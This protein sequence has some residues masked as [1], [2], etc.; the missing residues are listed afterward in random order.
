LLI[1]FILF[2]SGLRLICSRIRSDRL[3]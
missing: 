1:F 2:N 3:V